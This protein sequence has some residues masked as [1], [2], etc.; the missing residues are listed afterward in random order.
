VRMSFDWPEGIFYY[1]NSAVGQRVLGGDVE[2]RREWRGGMMLSAQ[3]GF[4]SSRYT[5]SPQKNASIYLPER[6]VPNQP[7]HLA[8]VRAVVPILPSQ[9][10]GAVR[11]SF[12]GPRRVDLETT[13]ETDAAVI[14]DIVLSGTLARHG[15]RWSAGLYNLFD[16]R[17]DLPAEPYASTVMPQVG[18]SLLLSVTVTR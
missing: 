6:R 15:V 9:L 1:R 7:S 5:A 8:S 18:R 10:S 14:A 17:Y 16:W 11:V 13:D 12:E 3:Y 4:Q 2:V